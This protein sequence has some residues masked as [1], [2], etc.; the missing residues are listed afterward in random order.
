MKKR[1]VSLLL[2]LAFLLPLFPAG[3]VVLAEEVKPE[4]YGT[5]L[6]LENN[7]AIN[8]LV[9]AAAFT[10]AGFTD[11]QMTFTFGGETTVATDYAVKD[12]YYYCTF[13]GL[14]PTSMGETVTATLSGLKGGD[15][16]YGEPV[17]ES[18]AAYCR[19]LCDQY[20]NDA[21]LGALIAD[22][23][24]YGAKAQ[25]YFDYDA[26]HPATSVLTADQLNKRTK[27]TPQ[28]ASCKS[29]SAIAGKELT[30]Y[31]ANLKLMDSIDLQFVFSAADLTGLSIEV[32]DG[33][34]ELVASFEQA[35]FEPW[36]SYY[37]VRCHTLTPDRMRDEL[38]VTAYRA[39]PDF[40]LDDPKELP[41]VG[42]E[43]TLPVSGTLCYSIESYVADAI[44]AY[45]NA[46]LNNLLYA[47]LN[48]GASVE[49][50]AEDLENG[51][52]V[53]DPMKTPLYTFDHTPTVDEMRAMA[54]RAMRDELSVQWYT[55]TT[56]SFNKASGAAVGQKTYTADKVYA[57]LPYTSAGI[58]IFQF[59]D[60]Y[61]ARSGELLYTDSETFNETIG[62][63]C[64]SSAAW[65]LFSVC[66]SLRGRCI[67]RYLTK[68]NGYIP[69]GIIDYDDS[70]TDFKD[71]TTPSILEVLGADD[72]NRRTWAYRA[73]AEIQPGDLLVYSE[74][75]DAGGHTMMAIEDAHVETNSSG[76][77]NGY[78]SYVMIQ[79]QRDGKFAGTASDGSSLSYFGRTSKKIYFNELYDG[80]YI[81]VTTA[82]F[83][84]EKPYETASVYAV[85]N[86]AAV[87]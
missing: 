3:T 84:G 6:F 57:G 46:K 79:D 65:G 37:R 13:R 76:Y 78:Y 56:I 70:I 28:A 80:G 60:Y 59:L 20:P 54:V 53:A 22:L 8:F 49:A 29:V 66:T 75:D 11:P 31:G 73:Y 43:G 71:K 68:S 2:T 16:V 50:Y 30:W 41:F 23:L 77:I 42:F 81:P 52:R 15:R 74:G 85:M 64:A 55:P 69:L 38:Y 26:D 36:E 83:L 10:G 19:K 58:G 32:R 25:T 62:N 21:V 27:T 47:M 40:D 9:D 61:N 45:N 12:G 17:T 86:D 7:I 63:T 87:T 14:T 51:K 5:S 34:G 33:D 24:T 44:L 72:A 67:S 4:I 35:D 39:A 82:E 1:I 18:V 48:Y